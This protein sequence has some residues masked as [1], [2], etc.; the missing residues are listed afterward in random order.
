[1]VDSIEIL[2]GIAVLVGAIPYAAYI[3]HSRQ[4]LLAAYLIFILTFVV[5]VG[6]LF[7][8]LT[9]L[10]IV[11]GLAPALGKPEVATVFFILILAPAFALATWQARKPPWQRGPPD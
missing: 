4:K 5:G 1:M 3:R 2:A 10:F 11:V 8:L 6:A 9:S 7:I